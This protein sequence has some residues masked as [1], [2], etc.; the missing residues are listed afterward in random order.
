MLTKA[1]NNIWKNINANITDMWPSI[2]V[3]FEQE[4]LVHRVKVATQNTR[5]DI[6]HRP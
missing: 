1:K 3:I 5:V 6:E 2:Q 4:E